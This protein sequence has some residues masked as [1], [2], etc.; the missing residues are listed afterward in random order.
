MHCLEKAAIRGGPRG[1][2][3]SLQ[4]LPCADEFRGATGWDLGESGGYSEVGHDGGTHVRLR[5]LF[6]GT[7]DGDVYTI[8]Y[9]TNGS[10][11]NVWSG[12][13]VDSVMARIASEK[14]PAEAAAES[15]R[16]F[17]F[18]TPKDDTATAAE[19]RSVRAID[20]TDDA[21][22][23]RTIVNTANNLRDNFDAEVAL[24]VFELDTTIF[25]RS[26]NAWENLAQAYDAAGDKEKA[27]SLRDKARG[28][29]E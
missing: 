21:A 25:P 6:N 27:Q 2:S 20:P 17:A 12:T 15:L 1:N 23:E 14:F 10:A 18:T 22:L 4:T 24:P 28:L 5:I 9:L 16:A 3:C 11:R 7:L 13:L 26:K 8:A 29:K 19:V